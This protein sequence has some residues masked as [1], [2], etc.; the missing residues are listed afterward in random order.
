MK[1]KILISLLL[2]TVIL[3]ACGAQAAPT[4]PVS[5]APAGSGSE[6]KVE[7]NNFAFNPSE[8]TVKVGDTVTW[9]NQDSAAHNVKAEDG[10]FSSSSLGK[11]DV[12]SYTFNTAGTYAYKCGFHANML[13]TVVVQP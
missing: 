10:S 4:A 5:S 13:G 6:F 11:G 8:I 12:F 9:T 2:T 3:A 1:T 7:I